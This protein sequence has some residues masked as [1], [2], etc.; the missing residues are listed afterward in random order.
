MLALCF[1]H[2]D[3][4]AHMSVLSLANQCIPLIIIMTFEYSLLKQSLH[5]ISLTP[6]KNS[7]NDTCR[8]PKISLGFN[9]IKF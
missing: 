5:N 6:R 7:T 1:F 2:V 9:V 3:I 4:T 8:I